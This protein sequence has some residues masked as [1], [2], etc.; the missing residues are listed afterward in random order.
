MRL[1]DIDSLNKELDLKRIDIFTQDLLTDYFRKEINKMDNETFNLYMEY[2]YS[3][4]N[5]KELIG[6]GSHLV[7][8][9]KK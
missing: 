7:D 2:V 6:I 4:S 1:D 5:K 9:V 3:V 8:I